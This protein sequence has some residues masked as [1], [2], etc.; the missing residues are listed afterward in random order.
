MKLKTATALFIVGLAAI[1]GAEEIG[2]KI[3]LN[4]ALKNVAIAQRDLANLRAQCESL[5]RQDETKLRDAI[6]AAT[7]AC[8][9]A[10][11]TLD[12]DAIECKEPAKPKP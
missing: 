1:R 4:L 2:Q 12:T 3:D 5:G 10:G 9:A 11:K 7:T 8:Q 6:A